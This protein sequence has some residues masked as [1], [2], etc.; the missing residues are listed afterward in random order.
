MPEVLQAAARS[1]RAQ[2]ASCSS[3]SSGYCSTPLDS[4]ATSLQSDSSL[5]VMGSLLRDKVS[6]RTFQL[7]TRVVESRV[8]LQWIL[9]LLEYRLNDA[10]S[11]CQDSKS[12]DVADGTEPRPES[13]L[14]ENISNTTKAVAVDLVNTF[15]SRYAE[16][17]KSLVTDA[18]LVYN[19]TA[20]NSTTTTP[21]SSD[22]AELDPSPPHSA[23]YCLPFM[24]AR[25][26]Y[27]RILH[28]L[29]VQQINW[30][31]IVAMMSFLR[32]LCEVLEASTQSQSSSDEDEN[33][34]HSPPPLDKTDFTPVVKQC[35]DGS[36][37]NG[38]DN[39]DDS[40]KKLTTEMKDRRIAS[41]HYIVWTTEFIHKESKLGDW[42]EEHGSWEGLEAFV[43]TGKSFQLAHLLFGFSPS[44]CVDCGRNDSYLPSFRTPPP[45]PPL[46]IGSWKRSFNKTF[47]HRLCLLFTPPP[48]PH[49]DF[50]IK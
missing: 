18:L 43:Q 41:L 23:Q 37:K 28:S 17:Y 33:E 27:I 1:F 45:P 3:S 12:G 6:R 7:L 40:N 21:S 20:S 34:V 44:F 8:S 36:A 50:F 13:W 32:A 47:L 31:R 38:N 35:V 15:E 19:S 48:S 22:E 9:P 4:L 39:D 5:G 10:P 42:I 2:S 25:D 49:H 29:F 30:G 16:G 26:R 11:N 46:L 24:N 14:P